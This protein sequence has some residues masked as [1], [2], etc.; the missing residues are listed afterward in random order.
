MAKPLTTDQVLEAW[1]ILR[2]YRDYRGEVHESP[3]GTLDAALAA[4]SA[5][6]PAPP[7]PKVSFQRA[8][9]PLAVERGCS[10]RSEDRGEL[11]PGEPA[12][13]GY[14][15][16]IDPDGRSRRLIVAPDRCYLPEPLRTW[17]WATQL[18]ALRS[19]KSWGIGDLADLRTLAA[20]AAERD[21]MVLIN[22]LHAVGPTVPQESSPYYPGSRCFLNPLYLRVEDVPGA[23]DLED[24]EDLQG[25][26]R[27]LNSDRRID[28]DA[29]YRLKMKAFERIWER[30]DDDPDFDAY[31]AER[32]EVLERFSIYMALAETYSG[33]WREWPADYRGPDAAEVDHFARYNRGRVRFHAWLQWLL[34]RQATEAARGTG[35][36]HDLAVG[37]DP[38][39]ADAWLWQEAFATDMHAGA[40]PDDFSAE[41]QNWAASVWEPGGL[42]GV[43]YEPFIETIRA[44]MVHGSG[45]RIDHVMSLFRLFWIPGGA[46]PAEGV[47]VKYPAD[48]LL[49]IVALES[50]RAR[51]LVIGEDLG[52]VEPY[53]RDEMC[54]RSIL[55]TTLMWFEERMPSELPALAMA[56]PN[57]HDLPTTA[58]LWTGS[59]SQAQIELGLDPSREFKQKI[60]DRITSQLDIGRDATVAEVVDRSYEALATSPPAIVM[61]SIEDAL[62]VEERHNLPGSMGPWNWSTALPTSL[63]EILA[64]PRVQRLAS[65]LAERI[66]EEE[67]TA[68][69]EPS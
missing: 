46:S 20:D 39:G 6:G 16:L 53:V 4:M 42:D 10:V 63:E 15:E 43:A 33:S 65:I 14:H 52:T 37:V 41:G 64:H 56:A 51:S 23:P 69:E 22:P 45:V 49:D 40:P 38:D 66:A 31:L 34:D 11:F 54:A 29:V 50:H 35:V 19:A 1:G 57:T 3:E 30:F 44:S 32:G 60:V 67:R 2:A 8:G 7:S 12:P 68:E 25:A 48:R 13:S 47:Y 59:D 55:S 9:E 36:I 27:A 58:G 5:E 21:G 62:E 24:L 26:G 61:G 17:G 18:Y 28:R